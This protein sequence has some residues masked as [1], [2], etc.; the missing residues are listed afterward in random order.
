MRGPAMAR[1][2]T[3]PSTIL[4][5]GGMAAAAIAGG[6][7]ALA[8]GVIAGLAYGIK[9]L[10][11]VA[12][13]KE[14][15]KVIFPDLGID[16][17]RLDAVGLSQMQD[18]LMARQAYRAAL[19]D[20]PAGPFRER[21][22]DMETRVDEAVEH[23][24]RLVTRAQSLRGYLA[25][26]PATDKA[27]ALARARVRQKEARGTAKEQVA[28]QVE[29]LEEQ[30]AAR[31]RIQAAHDGA[32]AKIGATTA[33][34]EQLAAQLTEIVLLA[35]D[36][37]AAAALPSARDDVARLVEELDSVRL[38]LDE[39]G[40]PVGDLPLASDASGGRTRAAQAE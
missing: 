33:R 20:V 3:T 36:K 30:L 15:A 39:V 23:L 5:T 4:V 22:E 17:A 35:D 12:R 7:P 2:M 28:A 8:V 32:V 11:T 13:P 6:L 10:F 38:A 24:Y 40:M 26:T 1:A 18:A 16:L 29:A 14:L 9:T 25:R 34:V 27:E 31:E 21:F 37:A 19:K